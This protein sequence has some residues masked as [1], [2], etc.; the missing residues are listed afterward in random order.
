ML[1]SKQSRLIITDIERVNDEEAEGVVDES[2][3]IASQ[4]AMIRKKH[5]K[6]REANHKKKIY[7]EKLKLELEKLSSSAT[8]ADCDSKSLLQKIEQLQ[9]ILEQN[10]KRH[11]DEQLC[12]KSYIY[13]LDRMKKE[14]IAMELKANS[15][16]TSLKSTKHVLDTETDMFRKIR[17]SQY[18]SK[19]MLKEIKQTIAYEQRK[20][21]DRI[22]QLE[23][24]IKQRQEVAFRRE[25]RQ[26][27]QAE[28][29]EAAANDDKDSQEAKIRDSILLNRMWYMSLCKKLEHEMLLN[30]DIE[31]AFLRIKS[32]T[33]LS[34]IN[35]VVERFLTR[36]QNY[37]TLLSAVQDA[38]RKLEELRNLNESARVRLGGSRFEEGF[39]SRK[40]Y[41]E[42]EECEQQLSEYYK[43]YAV[44]KEK[45]QKA[46]TG[47]NSVMAWGEKI[48]HTLEIENTLE[49]AS[50]NKISESKNTLEEM[51][52][53]ID[54]K[55]QELILPLQS[56]AVETKKI[57]EGFA[58]RKTQEIV[59][60]IAMIEGN[61][62][63]IDKKYLKPDGENEGKSSTKL[64]KE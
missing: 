39:N 19:V 28:I 37:S 6:T 25:E 59:T 22:Q 15:L 7:C 48:C 54:K 21:N 57:M 52:D 17:E 26:K 13:M 18:Q 46:V 44:A 33:G 11:E 61:T 27:R 20:K 5:D 8:F 4:L 42:I 29:S 9:Q 35:E 10:R 23:K 24:T 55:L 30:S 38:E 31:N 40:I 1:K 51:F 3:E 62:R 12:K 64:I 63:R 41:S 2:K 50:G 53:I 36:E 58:R 60:E 16:Q 56:E 49:I 45:M 47:Y 32:A 14:K 43:E 34:D